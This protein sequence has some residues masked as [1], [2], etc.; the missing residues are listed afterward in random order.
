VPTQDRRFTIVP[1]GAFSLAQ[2]ASFG[3]GPHEAG[4]GELLRMCFAADG[5]GSATGVVLRQVDDGS[6][7]GEVHGETAAEEARA[8]VARILSLEHDATGWER[9]G[10]RDPVLGALQQRF[11]GLRPVLFYSPYEAAA[12]AVLVARTGRTQA[13]R[14]RR[15]ISELAGSTLELAGE[16]IASFPSAEA[17]LELDQPIP[18]LTVEK[19]DR[20]H[21]IAR[22]ELDGRLAVDHL[23]E[24]GPE[25]AMAE[26]QQL[27]GIGPFYSALV[28][29]RGCGLTDVLSTL[30]PHSRRAVQSFYGLDHEPDDTELASIA[31]AWRPFRTWAT[32][33][34][35]AVGGRD[36][37]GG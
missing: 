1:K 19:R 21:G 27:P 34:L 11:H 8:Q 35:R 29:I 7:E 9:I 4:S 18:S 23:R 6:I 25:E 30:E 10:Q 33:A 22:A 26:L 15:T 3:F 12:W 31:E 14:V 13:R 28:V 37:V 32:V 20:L 24:L 16:R 36:G 5:S 17:L 2:A